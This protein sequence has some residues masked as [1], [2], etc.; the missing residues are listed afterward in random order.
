VDAQFYPRD[1]TPNDTDTSDL[2]DADDGL[3]LY[4]KWKAWRAIGTP[5]ENGPL[6][7][8]EWE[9][10]LE[11]YQNQNDTLHEWP[12]NIFDGAVHDS[13]GFGFHR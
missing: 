8:R 7:K 3:I 4:A 6:A 9:N 10:L 13:G 1:F 12:G 11:D 5:P 2:N